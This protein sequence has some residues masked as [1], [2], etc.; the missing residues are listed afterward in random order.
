M[1]RVE[2]GRGGCRF[3]ILV[4]LQCN[5]GGFDRRFVAND[6]SCSYVKRNCSADVLDVTT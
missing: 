1:E 6:W 4:Y 2:K 5:S 3:K